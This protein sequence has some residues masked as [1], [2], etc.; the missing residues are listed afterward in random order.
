MI[1]VGFVQQKDTNQ[2]NFRHSEIFLT[3]KKYQMIDLRIFKILNSCRML[4]I[5][6]FRFHLMLY[7][8]LIKLHRNTLTD[9]MTF[10]QRPI[11]K[12]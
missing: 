2:T 5:N 6:L 7:C 12:P 1:W 11:A 3:F 9:L 8:K 10:T 4:N